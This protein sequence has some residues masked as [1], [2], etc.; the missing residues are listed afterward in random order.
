MRRR[1]QGFGAYPVQQI[2]PRYLLLTGLYSSQERPAGTHIY[3]GL[4]LLRD[5]PIS[6]ASVLLRRVGVLIDTAAIQRLGPTS[7]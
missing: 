2:S 4:E 3:P 1:N 6:I 5:L 7:R